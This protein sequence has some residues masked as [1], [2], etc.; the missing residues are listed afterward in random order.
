CRISAAFCAQLWHDVVL[1]HDVLVSFAL[2]VRPWRAFSWPPAARA[3][4]TAQILPPQELWRDPRPPQWHLT[5]CVL[6][7][8]RDPSTVPTREQAA[9]RLRG[10]SRFQ[11]W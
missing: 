1:L 3:L 8:K 4:Q 5:E 7:L 10:A 9:H 2:L 11:K 6:L